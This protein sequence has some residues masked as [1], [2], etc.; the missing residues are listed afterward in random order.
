M[1]TAACGGT[2][3]DTDQHA[4]NACELFQQAADGAAAGGGR[5]AVL[6]MLPETAKEARASDDEALADH[7]THLTQVYAT[8][9]SNE[10]IEALSDVMADC[11]RIEHEARG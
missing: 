3:D 2:T 4:A 11:Y 7:A 9:S 8:A 1:A 6:A 10:L 5:E